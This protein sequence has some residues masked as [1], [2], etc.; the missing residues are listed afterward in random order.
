MC[1][2]AGI[3]GK[4]DKDILNRML[5]ATTHR[6]PDDRGVYHS[7]D[8]SIGMNR[9][10]IIDLSQAGHQPMIS[11]DGR[12]VLVYN[13]EIYNFL[14]ER[15]L[16]ENEGV[17]FRSRT[18][19]EVLLHL[20]VKYGK[21]CVYR[22]R[23]MFA[24][25]VWDEQKK[26]L[27]ACRDHFGI[28]PLYYQIINNILFFCSEIK[29]FLESGV[30]NKIY[31]KIGLKLYLQYGTIPAPHTILDNVK[32]L[33]PGHY[34]SFK[35]G[36]IDIKPYWNIPISNDYEGY[37]YQEVRSSIRSLILSSVKEQLISDVPL[38]IFLSGGLD[39]NIV[40][41]AARIAGHDKLNTFTIGFEE[42]AD[43]HDETKLAESSADYYDTN[44]K[45]AI[46]TKKDI[47]ES[48]PQF[49]E[50]LD[51]PSTDGLNSYM[52]A[53]YSKQFIT[54]SLSGLGGDELFWG[55]PWQYEMLERFKMKNLWNSLPMSSWMPPRLLNKI[56]AEKAVFSFEEL[57]SYNFRN[58]EESILRYL[59]PKLFKESIMIEMSKIIKENYII[60]DSKENFSLP[61]K[62]NT[63]KFIT[64]TDARIF[65]ANRLREGDALSMIN[66]LEV[67]FPFLDKRLYNFVMGLDSKVLFPA[68]KVLPMFSNGKKYLLYESFK[69]DLPPDFHERKKYG[70]VLP[71]N[72]WLKSSFKEEM[73]EMFS[74]GL[75]EFITTNKMK[76]LFTKWKENGSES[77]LIWALFILIKWSKKYQLTY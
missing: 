68:N 49:I 24:F 47:V 7:E 34:F 10:A 9:L 3:I 42:N 72:Y 57:Y 20:F 22:L 50:G 37:P 48:L 6:G 12:F 61:N 25:V 64:K 21:E 41:A 43:V 29:G 27:F 66:S 13:G 1:G 40:L 14:E 38:G 74:V 67:R 56:K 45:K 53:K 73:E 75:P 69:K 58:S 35:K 55:Y 70:F 46:L 32:S 51:Q 4:T 8:V 77:S 16:L 15:V 63:V 2:I 60:S 5:V 26:E 31:S 23:G 36:E 62:N 71:I 18:D 76:N 59:C 65:M 44:H 11:E 54:V 28:K 33:L 52:V 39:S 19:S 17:K 30:S